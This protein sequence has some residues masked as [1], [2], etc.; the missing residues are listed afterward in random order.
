MGSEFTVPWAAGTV[1][2]IW[3]MDQ[4]DNYYV[5]DNTTLLVQST[6][7][8][9]RWIGL[10]S[11]ST[12]GLTIQW[13]SNTAYGSWQMD[14]GDKYYALGHNLVLVQSTYAGTP[15]VGV[16]AYSTSGL[17]MQWSSGNVYGDWQMDQGDRYYVLGN[18]LLLVQ[19]TNGV[20]RIG[21]VTTVGS[22]LTV[23]WTA[24]GSYG[25]WV[26]DT[27]DQYYLLGNNQLLVQSTYGGSN[28]YASLISYSNSGLTVQGG[29]QNIIPPSQQTQDA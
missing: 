17:T 25:G 7:A 3:R 20:A 15:W 18:N 28:R 4:C 14:Q 8:G 26:M 23:V 10:A 9:T 12:S 16:A 6:Y 5:L 2:D 29:A 21:L 24:Q 11:Y 22:E 1:Y 19:S 13:S 27:G